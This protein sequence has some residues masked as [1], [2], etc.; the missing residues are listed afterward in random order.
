MIPVTML[1]FDQ[2]IFFWGLSYRLKMVVTLHMVYS[3]KDKI[4]L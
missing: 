2:G 3:I 4:W 1:N